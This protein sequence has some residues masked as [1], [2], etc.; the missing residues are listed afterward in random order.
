M[1]RIISGFYKLKE[2]LGVKQINEQNKVLVTAI[3]TAASTTIIQELKKQYSDI[4]IYGADIYEQRSVATSKDVDRFF[5]FPSAVT[6]RKAYMKYLVDFCKQ[7]EINYIFAT[8]DEEVYDLVSNRPVFDAIGVKLCLPDT[9]TVQICHMKDV[10]SQWIKEKYPEIWIK[11]YSHIDEVSDYP[12]F[13]KPIEGRASNDCVSIQSEMELRDFFAERSIEDF[14]IQEKCIGKIVAVDISRDK[15]SGSINICQREE[16]LRNSSG[17]GIAV[18][19][20]EDCK[21]QKIC[22]NLADLLDLNGVVNAEFFVNEN[23]YKIIEINPRFPAGTAYSCM[24]GVNI[25][26]DAFE[27]ANQ[28]SIC[29]ANPIIGKRFARRYETYEL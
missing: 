25:V 1:V 12:V 8:I 27:I 24:A 15:T 3:G 14:L 11:N 6:D 23:E 5:V 2:L 18:E 19:I 4:I 16:L 22:E 28:R 9:T 26:S 20:I 29:K 13:V 21:L 17:S 7:N 10:F